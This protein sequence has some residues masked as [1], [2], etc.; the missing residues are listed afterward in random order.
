[1]SGQRGFQI[2]RFREAPFLQDTDV[3]PVTTQFTAEDAELWGRKMEAGYALGQEA[4][5]LVR[6]PSLSILNIWNKPGY[7]TPLHSHDADCL[8]YILAG[9]VRLGTETLDAG[10]SFFIPADM[11]YTYKV[12]PDGAEV[13]EIRR[14]E[15]WDLK[16]LAKNPAY[17]EKAIKAITANVDGWRTARRPP[18]NV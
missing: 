9:S 12:G 13:L 6:T 2:F 1:M 16:L 4:R 7:P 10:D 5:V 15:N 3:Q 17:F 14:A 11:P 8:Y 18:R